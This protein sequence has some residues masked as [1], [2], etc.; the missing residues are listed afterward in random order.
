MEVGGD[1]DKDVNTRIVMSHTR[2]GKL[3]HLW[4]DKHLYL[5]LRLRLYKSST[6]I[7]M[8]YESETWRLD[9]STIKKLNGVN[10]QMVP[11]C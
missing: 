7:I 4:K 3:H 8:T 6:C 5:N 10:T 1:Q 11:I 2:F 9:E